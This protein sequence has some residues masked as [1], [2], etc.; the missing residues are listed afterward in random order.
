M[1]GVTCW[2]SQPGT[3]QDT[4]SG[5]GHLHPDQFLPVCQ[6][7]QGSLIEHGRIT[8]IEVLTGGGGGK[9]EVNFDREKAKAK[10]AD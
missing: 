6:T 1:K 7:G 3:N 5:H 2:T 8:S 9:S 10:G 4:V